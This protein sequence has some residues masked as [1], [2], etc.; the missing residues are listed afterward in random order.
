MVH[1]REMDYKDKYLVMVTRNG[2][3]KRIEIEQLKN[4]RTNGIRALNLDEGDELI[5]VRQTDGT[6]NILI[7]THDG[8][9]ICISESDVRPRGRT[10]T[11]VRGI[12]LRQGDYCVGAARARE[13]GMLLTVTENGYGKR[14][15]IE[16]YLRGGEDAGPQKRGGMG[17][18]NYNCTSKTGKVADIKVVDGTED[19]LMISDDGTIIRMAVDSISVLGRATQGVRLMRVAEDSKVISIA[20]TDREET[21]ET[22]TVPADAE[23]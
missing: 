4:I 6:A 1:A 13:G 14:T 12:K 8:A 11:G 22:E 7:A 16:D 20:R 17:L 23:E 3:V 5:S 18:R 21:S 15:P 2:T 9:A 10:A 19:I